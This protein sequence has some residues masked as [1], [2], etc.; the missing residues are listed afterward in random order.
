MQALTEKLRTT[1]E[2]CQRIRES[3]AEG[4]DQQALDAAEQ[5]EDGAGDAVTPDELHQMGMRCGAA[6][7]RARA[8]GEGADW[9]D[10]PDIG[11]AV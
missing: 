4:S 3:A 7:M 1:L 5:G 2:E 9:R 11:A 6:A 8:E 10:M